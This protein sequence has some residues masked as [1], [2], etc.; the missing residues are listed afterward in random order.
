MTIIESSI[1]GKVSQ[2]ECE[3]GLVVT[4][5]VV[6]VIDGSTSKTPYRISPDMRNGRYAMMLISDFIRERLQP[7]ATAD[8][9]CRGVTEYI[10]GKVYVP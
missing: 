10:Q 1:I 4:D 3:D 5:D 7:D 9:F 2:E 8:D 6:A